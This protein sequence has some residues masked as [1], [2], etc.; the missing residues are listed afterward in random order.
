MAFIHDTIQQEAQPT[1]IHKELIDT[2]GKLYVLT[3]SSS[4]SIYQKASKLSKVTG[5]NRSRCEQFVREVDALQDLQVKILKQTAWEIVP[6][7][8]VMGIV[9]QEY[10]D[11][12]PDTELLLGDSYVIEPAIEGVRVSEVMT[13]DEL[14]AK[15]WEITLR[16]YNKL[17]TAGGVLDPVYDI[18]DFSEL[19]P[20]HDLGVDL[21]IKSFQ[22]QTVQDKFDPVT[23]E[24]F[25]YYKTKMNA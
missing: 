2:I 13:H 25:D 6:V 1:R 17:F 5:L 22:S 3:C 9:D 23:Q 4:M 11:A 18:T 12:N 14:K 24:E 8:S 16:D 19:Q 7:D 21:I 15:S 10:L 20:A